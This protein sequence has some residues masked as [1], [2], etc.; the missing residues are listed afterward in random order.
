MNT[1]KISIYTPRF[2]PHLASVH[3]LTWILGLEGGVVALA[4]EKVSL[5]VQ[6]SFM[7]SF[8][9]SDYGKS[10]HAFYEIGM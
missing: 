7:S 10:T 8:I 9:C 5:N 1:L 6:A 4:Q 2:I 3:N